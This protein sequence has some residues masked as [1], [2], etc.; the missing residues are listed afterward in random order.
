MVLRGRIFLRYDWK[1]KKNNAKCCDTPSDSI[2]SLELFGYSHYHLRNVAVAVVWKPP[3]EIDKAW[4]DQWGRCRAKESVTS[5]ANPPSTSLKTSR[6]TDW[7]S[8]L[9]IVVCL[10][11]LWR[12]RWSSRAC[13]IW[14][15][16]SS[17]RL[18]PSSKVTGSDRVVSRVNDSS[19]SDLSNLNFW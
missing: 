4:Y 16:V 7:S 12:P 3:S 10:D 11:P 6:M 14:R 5:K 15:L 8:K 17:P 19:K 13:A 2:T 1:G 9:E 18:W